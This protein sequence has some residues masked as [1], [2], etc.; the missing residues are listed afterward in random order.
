MAQTR[1][2]WYPLY[3]EKRPKG[4]K[5]AELREINTAAGGNGAAAAFALGQPLSAALLYRR[6]DPAELPFTVCSELEV[7]RLERVRDARPRATGKWAPDA[8][9]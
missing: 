1:C 4:M 8:Q 7:V 5:M 3:D 6:C 2:G 9:P